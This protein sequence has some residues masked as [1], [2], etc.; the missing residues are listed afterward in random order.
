MD[1]RQNFQDLDALMCA[2]ARKLWEC[3]RHAEICALENANMSQELPGI[4]WILD[5]NP[6]F[7][8]DFDGLMCIYF[9]N[10]GSLDGDV[11][12]L[13]NVRI[14]QETYGCLTETPG[15]F[16]DFDG[17]IGKFPRNQWKFWRRGE[18]F[19]LDGAKIPQEFLGNLR[20]LDRNP[21]FFRAFVA[22]WGGGVGRG[23]S[24]QHPPS[25]LPAGLLVLLGAGWQFRCQKCCA[26]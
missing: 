11:C 14:S 3:W 8:H 24:S 15:F 6:R 2:F 17:L 4:L 16:S 9:R 13:G 1:V 5:R 10:C 22:G 25:P 7:F 12:T 26:L 19:T 18:V 21:F 23:S 20:I